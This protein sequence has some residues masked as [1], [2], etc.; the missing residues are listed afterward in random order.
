MKKQRGLLFLLLL[1]SGF[2]TINAQS[3]KATDWQAKLEKYKIKTSLGIQLWSSYTFDQKV[4]N[5][6]TQVYDA[7]DNRLNFQLRR[8]RLSVSGRPYENL[9]FKLTA[10]MDL[11]GR[12]LLSGTEAGVNNGASPSFRLWNA[13][14]QW[15]AIPKSESVNLVIGYMAPQIGR[16]S[17]TA[18]LRSNSLEKSWSQNYL[19]RH[20]TGIGPGRAMGVNLGG[21]IS[22][23][24]SQ[25]HWRYD[26]GVF[27]P[28]F[29]SYG[30]NSVGDHFSPLIVG[31]WVMEIGDPEAK[32][33]SLSHKINYF[34]KRNGL[35]LAL[36]GATQGQTDLYESNQAIGA[37]FLFNWG[38]F[39]V[40]A[41]WTLLSRQ[42]V[43]TVD[44]N[45]QKEKVEAHTGYVRFGY[46]FN[47]NNG[48]VIEPVAM[49]MFFNGEMD[50]EYQSYASQLKSMSGEEH[51]LN[52]GANLYLNPDLKLSFF[53]THRGADAGDAGPGATV[54]NYF[55]QGGV[56]AIQR[57]NWIGLGIVGIF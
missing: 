52:I 43:F 42:G 57:G 16:E 44:E 1:L 2:V 21:L 13:F 26:L 46:N 30:G 37:D 56:G 4:F 35:S 17:I 8:T 45:R 12:D 5:E 29:E 51:K 15:R 24:N 22:K 14:V 31:R 55:N 54:N 50:A 27:T 34:G 6:E 33:Y 18:A 53:Y 3:E 47:L 10:A 25:L 48:W 38:H 36:T 39:N 32:K 11:V 49:W 20:L 9:S 41:E 40:D 23:E 28:Q 7:V 19:R